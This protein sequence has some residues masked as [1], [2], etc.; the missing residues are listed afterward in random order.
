MIGRS[1]DGTG[2]TLARVFLLFGV[3]SSSLSLQA[4]EFPLLDFVGLGVF[5]IGRGFSS[6]KASGEGRLAPKKVARAVW[7]LLLSAEEEDCDL[8][9]RGGLGRTGAAA[10]G[11]NNV[12]VERDPVDSGDE[13]TV[14]ASSRSSSSLRSSSGSDVKDRASCSAFSCSSS[15]CRSDAVNDLPRCRSDVGRTGRLCAARYDPFRRT[16]GATGL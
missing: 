7:V 8:V 6:T 2:W 13:T 5:R 12:G 15:S 14:N 10:S 11:R 3:S 16:G 9:R 4:L 1:A